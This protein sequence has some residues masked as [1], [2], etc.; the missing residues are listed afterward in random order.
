MKLLDIINELGKP[1]KVY[2]ERDPNKQI[3]IADL[4]PEE[5]DELMKKG[6]VIVRMAPD[7]TRPETTI[8]QV[9]NLPKIDQIKKDVIQNK[10]EF[11][12]FTFSSNPDIKNTA[13]EINKLYNSLFKAMNALDKMLELQKQGR[14]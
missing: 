9:I 13:K 3:T 1:E 7:P 2:A 4:T 10:R 11:D 12:V 6:T 8:S 5:R 14:I